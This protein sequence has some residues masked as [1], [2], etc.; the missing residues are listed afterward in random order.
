MVKRVWFVLNTRF[1]TE[2]AYGITTSLTARAVDDLPDFKS[3]IITPRR[4]FKEEDIV[5]SIEIKMPWN[6]LYQSLSKS[7]YFSRFSFVLWKAPY[8]LKISR[9]IQNRDEVIWL[10]DVH[11]AFV[12]RLLGF[13][14]I[15]E[16]HRRPNR[17]SRLMLKWLGKQ[18]R[19]T[20]VFITKKLYET[21]GIEVKSLVVFGMAVN[22][23]DLLLSHRKPKTNNLTVGYLGSPHSSGNRLSLQTFIGAARVAQE[24]GLNIKFEVVGISRE[25]V[26]NKSFQD[27]Y[28]NINFW[29][30]VKRS[31]VFKYIDSFDIGIV[32]YPDTLYFQDS[33]PIKIV[34]YAARRILILASN[35]LAHRE[36]LG[37]DKAYYFDSKSPLDLLEKV[38]SISKHPDLAT[39]VVDNAF[40][41]VSEFSYQSRAIKIL[42]ALFSNK[43]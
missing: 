35:T 6:F 26:D 38:L 1:P 31:E 37:T 39:E 32:I 28:S 25:E 43:G 15:C 2:K 13:P 8:A 19:V 12:M 24:K 29:G 30:R 17:F 42:E 10:R 16:I 40:K 41:W 33:F 22:K 23:N 14:T 3:F 18:S 5:E 34:E 9:Y 4:D 36:I 11:L 27:S 21:V 20:I 7:R